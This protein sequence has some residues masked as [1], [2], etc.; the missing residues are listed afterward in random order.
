[1]QEQSSA[2]KCEGKGEH[3]EILVI[4]LRNLLWGGY[5]FYPPFLA[6]PLG[7]KGIYGEILRLIPF[8]LRGKA[9]KGE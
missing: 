7:G 5:R 9:R 8:P 2:K 1:L 3:E 6:F 4:F